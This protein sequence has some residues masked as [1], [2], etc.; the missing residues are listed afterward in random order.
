[1]AEAA[2]VCSKTSSSY[3]TVAKTSQVDDTLF[4]S[5]S[6]RGK[7]GMKASGTLSG[8]GAGAAAGK[9]G[10]GVITINQDQIHRMLQPSPVLTLSQVNALKQGAQQ[11]RDK[12]REHS[13]A[14]KARMLAMEE[15]RKKKVLFWPTR[16]TSLA[17]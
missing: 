15:E 16:W 11:A 5:K 17:I 7:A 2:S 3:R 4:S 14:R 10:A 8:K 1:M 12:E 9:S 6:A 13:N